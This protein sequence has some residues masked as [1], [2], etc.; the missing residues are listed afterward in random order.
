MGREFLDIF[1]EWADSYDQTVSG[2][3]P[4][5]MEVFSNYNQIL[6]EVANRAISTVLEFGVGTG[7]L[8]Q[9]LLQ[10]GLKV[11][12]V[13]PSKEMRQIALQK[14]PSFVEIN[15]GDFLTFPMQEGIQSIVS[16]YAFHHLTDEEKEKAFRIY[17]S[18]LDKGQKIVFADTMFESEQIFT[19]MIEDAKQKGYNRLAGDLLSEYY[20][21]I[22]K[23][24]DMVTSAGFSAD[25]KQLN[26]FVWIMEA[27]KR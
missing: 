21:T 4:Q 7:N 24:K 14:L 27:I 20:T 19:T 16:T 12:G 17:S 3:D 1:A 10:K 11:T 8:T 2:H 26:Q 22:P 15:E 13:E 6:E 25:F 18:M 9:V 5:Y 23:L